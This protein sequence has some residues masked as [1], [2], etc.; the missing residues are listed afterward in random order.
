MTEKVVQREPLGNFKLIGRR[1]HG[2]CPPR[3]KFENGL[4][5]RESKLV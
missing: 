4:A 2:V 5:V 3:G 1:V